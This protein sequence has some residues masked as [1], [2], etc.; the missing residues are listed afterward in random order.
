MHSSRASFF[1]TRMQLAVNATP[2][3]GL[4]RASYD[5]GPQ[6]G[7]RDDVL[8]RSG[9]RVL[10]IMLCKSCCEQQSAV[11]PGRPWRGMGGGGAPCS[12]WFA[13]QQKLCHTFTTRTEF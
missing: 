11:L 4:I 10:Q 8:V 3:V 12:G 13:G 6:Y 2:R 1:L 5:G 7:G 9:E